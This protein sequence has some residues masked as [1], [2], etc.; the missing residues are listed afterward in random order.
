MT[1]ATRS[2]DT[3]T[4][5]A[6]EHAIATVRLDLLRGFELRSGT[7][8][9]TLTPC[10]QRLV[11]YV[12]LRDRAV[13]RTQVSGGLWLDASETRANASLRSALWRLPDV[14]GKPIV[15]ASTTHLWLRPDVEVDIR[16]AMARAAGDVAAE[17]VAGDLARF[18]TDLLP[19]WYDDWVIVERE[20][21]RQ[22]RIHAL[23]RLCAQLTTEGRFA[24]AIAAGTAAVA[25]EPLRENGHRHLMAVHVSAGNVG[26]AVRQRDT[27]ARLLADELG[28]SPSPAMEA[29]LEAAGHRP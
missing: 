12:A 7:D 6:V 15:S 4:R 19:D 21:Y 16:H 11:A 29:M 17:D 9:V 5:I 25:A 8:V 20:R 13:R 22:V 2:A 1:S 14:D 24:E 23:E 27:Y 3:S 18:A 10:S 26:E 28:V